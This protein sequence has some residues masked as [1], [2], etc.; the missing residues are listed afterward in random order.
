[1]SRS[2]RTI[3]LL[4]AP[5][6]VLALTAGP[7]LARTAVPVPRTEVAAARVAV[8]AAGPDLT[9]AVR[10]GP[11]DDATRLSLAISLAP[12]DRAGLDAFVRAVATPSSPQYRHYLTVAQF[13]DR[14]GA[15]DASIAAVGSYLRS[16]GLTVAAPT[17]NRLTLA[18]TGTAA[19]VR[20]AFGV[21]VV[22]YR[23][24]DGRTF[25]AQ[26]TA[27][28]V[29]ADLAGIVADVA[30]LSDVARPAPRSDGQQ[31]D[32]SRSTRQPAAV[33]GLTPGTIRSAYNLTTDIGNGDNGKGVKVA[34][35]EFTAYK[36]SDIAFYDSNFALGSPAPSVV[37]VD[38]GTTDT[39]ADLEADLDIEVVQALAPAAQVAVYEAPN[40]DAG[41]VD[42]YDAMVSADVPVIATNWG[43]PE[44]QSTEMTPDDAIFE[45]AAAQGES[46]YADSSKET[47]GPGLPGGVDYPASD[48]YVTAVGGTDLTLTAANAW[49]KE[50]ADA[51]SGAGPS[52]EFPTPAYQVPV[53]HTANREVD[54][55]AADAGTPFAI[56]SEGAWEVVGG[57][58]AATAEW[59]GFTADYDTAA[60]ASA[61]PKLGYADPFLYGV[62]QS[63]AYASAFHDITVGGNGSYNAATG[64][65]MVTGWGSFNGG[66]FIADEL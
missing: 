43:A 53:N 27:P 65:D 46:V 47:T 30:G 63:K 37:K 11:V 58:G 24:A 33:S 44:A 2:R 26:S 22:D 3:A 9:G 38:G 36:A 1:M 59:A 4:A 5:L 57:V 54:D 15:T 39:S 21:A 35:A 17:A 8:P 48:P 60:A 19:Q 45:E 34:V 40:T 18:A 42:L 51:G 25:Y 10:L 64:W 41:E 28:E 62:G 66:N 56:Y 31:P 32:A 55:V 14:Y 20:R 50:T 61:K 12:R 49:S 13:A 23:A 7:A 29:P 16:A 6:P 52:G